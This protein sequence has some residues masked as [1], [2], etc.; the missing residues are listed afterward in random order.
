MKKNKIQISR[1]KTRHN[2]YRVGIC[3]LT[4]TV[5]NDIKIRLSRVAEKKGYRDMSAYLRE[6]IGSAVSQEPINVDDIELLN[7][8]KKQQEEL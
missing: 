6:L 5:K 7:K 8:M 4:V 2:K 1:Q 3:K